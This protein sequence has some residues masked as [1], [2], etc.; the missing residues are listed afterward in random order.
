MQENEAR[1]KFWT[2]R[3]ESNIY[4]FTRCIRTYTRTWVKTKLAPFIPALCL[5]VFVD[6]VFLSQKIFF[7]F[8]HPLCWNVFNLCFFSACCC[9]RF[10]AIVD[11]ALLFPR[12]SSSHSAY[13]F[14]RSSFSAIS[15][16]VKVIPSRVWVQLCPG[17]ARPVSS[18]SPSKVKSSQCPSCFNSSVDS[19][20][21]Q[22]YPSTFTSW[23][24]GI[25]LRR[26]NTQQSTIA[27]CYSNEK[28]VAGGFLRL[29]FT[30]CF[31]LLEY[32]QLYQSS[33]L[34]SFLSLTHV[35]QNL[36]LDS[37][38]VSLA[39][40]HLSTVGTY[41]F[42]SDFLPNSSII[43]LVA[44]NDRSNRRVARFE[45]NL[46]QGFACLRPEKHLSQL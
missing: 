36:G 7:L 31:L 35:N 29:S 11:E 13:F 30:I 9:C 21:S 19:F 27:I 39:P 6:Q 20:F 46:S 37:I 38:W 2:F 14:S 23:L 16:L 17:R 45:S 5:D 44:G 43:R 18:I 28:R 10:Y 34:F 32:V 33:R 41:R 26:L 42:L 4:Q 3:R 25:I 8:E 15:S 24:S 22:L 40:C 1:N 12:L